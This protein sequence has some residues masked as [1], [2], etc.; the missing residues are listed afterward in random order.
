MDESL[1]LW[2][3]RLHWKQYVKD[4]AVKWRIKSYEL[5]ESDGFAR[6]YIVDFNVY[7]DKA[8]EPSEIPVT[9]KAV[10]DLMDSD[11]L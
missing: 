4:K 11:G 3:G 8:V 2:K 1:M 5:C 10:L 7:T 9:Q 6:G